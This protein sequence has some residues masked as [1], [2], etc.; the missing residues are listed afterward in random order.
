LDDDTDNRGTASYVSGDIIEIP[1]NNYKTQI[2]RVYISDEGENIIASRDITITKTYIEEVTIDP[3]LIIFENVTE[4]EKEKIE[5]L[6][7]ILSQLPQQ[8]RLRA[9]S[10]IQKLQENWNDDTE[11]T[12]TILDF[13]NYIFEL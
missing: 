4:S 7:Q 2:I 3:D 9:L 12:R 11:K 6:K 8:Q 13:E 1:L 5:T 10:Y